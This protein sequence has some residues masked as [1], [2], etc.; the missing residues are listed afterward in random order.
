MKTL[1]ITL[2]A[3]ALIFAAES[4]A[5]KQPPKGMTAAQV[6]SLSYAIGVMMGS[7]FKNSKLDY[8]DMST[9]SKAVN[10]IFNDKTLRFDMAMANEIIQAHFMKIEE[11]NRAEASVKGAE[12]LEEGAKFLAENST[13]AGVVELPGGLQ[14]KIVS[15]GSGIKP[16]PTDTV[17]VHY[18]GT[19]IDGTEFDSSYKLGKTISFPLNAVIKGWTEGLQHV[20]EG[21]TVF[22]YIPADLAYGDSSTGTITPNSTLIF[23]IELIKVSKDKSTK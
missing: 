14:Y 22:L 16:G 5:Q 12:N 17:E 7:N 9:F 8:L 6:D 20:K 4:C 19:L 10:D 23:E 18:R 1:K 11:Q 21:S 15:E 2:F 13:K 3:L